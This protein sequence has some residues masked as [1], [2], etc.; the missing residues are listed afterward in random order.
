[1]VTQQN[2]KQATRSL[3]MMT[4]AT[5]QDGPVDCKQKYVMHKAHPTA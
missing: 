3:L 4:S 2:T 5:L 1:M